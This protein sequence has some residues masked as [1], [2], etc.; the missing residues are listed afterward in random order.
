ENI[1]RGIEW[2]IENRARYGIRVL[3]ISLG[4]DHDV[5]FGQSLID[6]TAEEAVRAGIVVVAA[7][8]NSGAE[9]KRSI[10]PANAPSVITVGGYDDHNELNNSSPDLYN[11]NFG[12]TVDGVLKP[13][14]I[15]PAMWV[16][17]P[18]LPGTESY[19]DA[20]TLSRLVCVPDYQLP[21]LV[22]Q[23]AAKDKLLE[24]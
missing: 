12:V 14:V 24:A 11:S 16:A 10:P 15:A 13:E 8:G 6:Q 23:L 17:A 9:G 2:V 18:I 1:A 21:K 5:S 3:N 20:E 19:R 4:G 22:A 7:A